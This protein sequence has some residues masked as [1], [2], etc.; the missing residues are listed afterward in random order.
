ME[1]F[2]NNAPL[3]FNPEDAGSIL[4]RNLEIQDFMV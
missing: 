3:D 4:L 1:K 2:I